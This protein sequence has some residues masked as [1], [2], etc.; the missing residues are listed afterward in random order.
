M[1]L[2]KLSIVVIVVEQIRNI[3]FMESFKYLNTWSPVGGIIEV[4][5]KTLRDRS[6]LEEVCLLRICSFPQPPVHPLSS[7]CVAD[8]VS[9]SFLLQPLLPYLHGNYVLP[10]RHSIIINAFCL[11]LVAFS[12]GV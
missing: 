3:P 5:I 4:V 12:H 8:M 6:L 9:L 1:T 7:L 11:I 2:I 10:F